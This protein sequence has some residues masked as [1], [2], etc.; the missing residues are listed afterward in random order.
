[1]SITARIFL[2]IE[3]LNPNLIRVVV[4]NFLLVMSVCT[5]TNCIAQSVPTLLALA[6]DFCLK[7]FY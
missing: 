5:L 2:V 7:K 1:M 4:V 3:K 6:T